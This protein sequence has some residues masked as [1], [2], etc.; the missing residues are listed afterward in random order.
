MIKRS[1]CTVLCLPRIRLFCQYIL[2]S[3]RTLISVLY[4]GK[5]YIYLHSQLVGLFTTIMQPYMQDLAI[6]V[7]TNTEY[8]SVKN[9]KSYPMRG[10]L[11]FYNMQYMCSRNQ[12]C[13]NV[14]ISSPFITFFRLPTT[15]ILKTQIGRLFSRHI[16]VA[17]ISITLSPRLITS[18]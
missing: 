17:V 13:T 7:K 1:V 5:I 15:S 8:Q 11:Y 14:P 6:F 3:G 16:A 4:F 2:P 18:S 9:L 12:G 10:A